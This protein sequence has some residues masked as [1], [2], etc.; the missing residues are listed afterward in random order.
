MRLG[1]LTAD[2]A[3]HMPWRTTDGAN[4]APKGEPEMYVLMEGVFER[5]RLTARS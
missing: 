1:S 3:R 4:F 2:L 5:G